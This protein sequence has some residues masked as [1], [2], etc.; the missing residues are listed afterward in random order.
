MPT[1]CKAL[2]VITKPYALP[3][4]GRKEESSS[5]QVW[6]TGTAGLGG[7]Q[8]FGNSTPK[9]SGIPSNRSFPPPQDTGTTQRSCFCAEHIRPTGSKKE[10]TRMEARR[11]AK[12][13]VLRKAHDQRC[14]GTAA[15]QSQNPVHPV[16]QA[17]SAPLPSCTKMSN[18]FLMEALENCT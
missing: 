16:R 6:G 14:Q 8:P 3:P 7:T 15:P 1:L 9:P 10:F 5:R 2:L 4:P 12:H 11:A 13:S 18:C 17:G